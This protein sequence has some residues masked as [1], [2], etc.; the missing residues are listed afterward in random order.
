MRQV[1]TLRLA[2][3]L[4]VVALVVAVFLAQHTMAA[5]VQTA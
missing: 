2:V 3:G 1:V 4:V 5:T